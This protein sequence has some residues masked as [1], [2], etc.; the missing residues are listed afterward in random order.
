MSLLLLDHGKY[1]PRW[2]ALGFGLRCPSC[3]WHVWAFPEQSKAERTYMAHLRKVHHISTPQ[4][5]LELG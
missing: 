5:D 4:I 1:P 3:G 2:A